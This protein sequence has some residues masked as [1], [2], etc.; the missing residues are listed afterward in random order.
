MCMFGGGSSGG[1]KLILKNLT[2]PNRTHGYT[3]PA[4]RW[5]D[6]LITVHNESKSNL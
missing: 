3:K 1:G 4:A 2:Q 6:E 5:L